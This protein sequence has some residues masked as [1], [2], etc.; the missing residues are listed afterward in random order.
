MA[1]E[2]DCLTETRRLE[3]ACAAGFAAAALHAPA[4][5]LALAAAGATAQAADD[6]I[7][8]LPVL[9]R[10]QTDYEP[11]GLLANGWF[12]YP[13]ITAGLIYD[14]NVFATPVDPADDWALVLAPELRAVATRET[15][16]YQ[17]DV[18]A[19]HFAY[20][21]FD[22]EDRTDAHARFRLTKQI[23]GDLK[24]DAAFEAARR[25]ELQG[26]S[27]VLAD[28]AEPIPFN[29]LRA[30]TA[31]TKT[32]NRFGVMVGGRIRNL[33]YEDVAATGGGTLEQDFRDGVIYTTTLKP[34]YEF[35]PGYRAFARIDLSRR[36]YAGEGDQNRDS[37]GYDARGGLDFRLT[38]VLFGSAELGYLTQDYDNPLIPPA[39]GLAAAA[40]VMW[41]MTPLMT[42]SFFAERS[43]SEMAS[44]EQEARLDFLAGAQIDYEIL[45]NLILSVEGAYKN[46]EFSGTERSDDIVKISAKLDYLINRRLNMGIHYI[47]LD[48]SSTNEIYDFSRHVVTLNVTAQH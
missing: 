9:Q 10:R 46:E 1:A 27:F 43:V 30:E 47:Y 45:R 2:G 24:W 7:A 38:P 25:H 21:T 19:K 22:S 8:N 20:Q 26:D 15:A 48:R 14:S 37:Q 12:F 31:V 35:S 29:D 18:G 40:R 6:E 3:R 4:M 17:F 23:T 11:I 32:F 44:P 16:T 28:A 41:L 39:E 34:F 42:V 36:D 33:S 5:L 13:R